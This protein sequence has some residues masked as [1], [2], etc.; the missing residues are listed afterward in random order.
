MERERE[1]AQAA[2][3]INCSDPEFPRRC[4]QS[5]SFAVMFI[6]LKRNL[7]K[8]VKL[9]DLR[10]FL[11]YYSNPTSPE[12][13]LVDKKLYRKVR[14]ISKVLDLLHP[15]YI[16]FEKYHL[17]QEIVDNYGSEPSKKLLRDYKSQ[18]E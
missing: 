8:S 2:C 6:E 7:K 10:K 13:R 12:Y 15:K 18:W 1:P 16:N 14:S 4:S 9:K 3:H 17:L 11:R 5:G